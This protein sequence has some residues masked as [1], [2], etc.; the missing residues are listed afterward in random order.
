MTQILH[1]NTHSLGQT[2]IELTILNDPTDWAARLN[3]TGILITC[4]EFAK[5]LRIQQTTTEQQQTAIAQLF[6]IF[7]PS[8]GRRNK[9][10]GADDVE[11]I[12]KTRIDVRAYMLCAAFLIAR[13]RAP[14]ELVQLVCKVS[15][16]V[17][18][19][20]SFYSTNL[21][22]FLLVF[23]CQIYADP[24]STKEVRLTMTG[25][26]QA[27]HHALSMPAEQSDALFGMLIEE[28]SDGDNQQ[29]RSLRLGEYLACIILII[30]H[31]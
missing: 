20:R 24:T 11:N 29:K 2:N 25:M 9:D 12:G 16:G 5:C 27:M 14:L 1:T 18:E 22:S 4:A 6:A 8:V 28:H 21:V 26:R 3:A 19:K 31:A 23:V 13:D 17:H 10:V 7:A 30:V 15:Q